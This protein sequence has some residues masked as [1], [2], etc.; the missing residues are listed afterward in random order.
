M[1]DEVV[2][3]GEERDD[4]TSLDMTD[5]VI[6]YQSFQR[7][8]TL[9]MCLQMCEKM[10]GEREGKHLAAAGTSDPTIQCVNFLRLWPSKHGFPTLATVQL[11]CMLL[12][13]VSASFTGHFGARCATSTAQ[14]LLW[15]VRGSCF[16]SAATQGLI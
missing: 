15:R 12:Q 10:E 14:S 5:R 2:W 8:T 11:L 16:T 7:A 3:D 9:P 13:L 1:R 6:G 4:L